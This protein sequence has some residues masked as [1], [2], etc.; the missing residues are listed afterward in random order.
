MPRYSLKSQTDMVVA[1]CVLHNFIPMHQEKNT[2]PAAW[3]QPDFIPQH[4]A[5]DMTFP[6]MD[7]M[8][9]STAGEQ[10]QCT[11]RDRIA[12]ALWEDHVNRNR[13]CV[14]A[15]VP[16]VIPSAEES[17]TT[18]VRL[19]LSFCDIQPGDMADETWLPV[20]TTTEPRLTAG[21]GKKDSQGDFVSL[22][23]PG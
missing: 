20:F 21:A 11:L 3:L 1:C 7:R 2:T 15:R 8:G 13:I 16:R 10:E 6:F 18:G 12:T 19:R 14:C 5:D 4:D 23:F 22:R 9:P 17:F